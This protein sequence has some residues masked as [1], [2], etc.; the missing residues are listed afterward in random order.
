MK[1]TVQKYLFYSEQQNPRLKNN[2]LQHT[3][4]TWV[5]YSMW[6]TEFIK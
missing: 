4:T 2:V 5:K 6:L 3:L 1:N